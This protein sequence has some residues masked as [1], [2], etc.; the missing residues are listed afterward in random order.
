MGRPGT[1]GLATADTGVA[2]RQVWLDNLRVV[3]IGGVI[4]AHA[5]TAY[6]VEVSWYYEE[7]TT[8]E[9]ARM[10]VTF[11]VFL[12]AIFGLGPLFFVA[13][14]LSAQSLGRAGPAAFARTRL[15]RLGLPL[16][17]FVVVIDPLADYL[18]DL[19]GGH[20]SLGDYLL[21]RTSTRDLGP[22]WFV[23][24]LLTFSLGYAAWRTVRHPV[25]PRAESV[26]PAQLLGFSAAIA[27][28]SWV[29][30]QRW[31]YTDA[32]PFNTNVGHW[33]QAAG[34]FAL[35]VCCSERGWFDTLTPRRTHRQGWL[36]LAGTA[37]IAILAGYSLAAD[38]FPSMTGG[39]HWQS[40]VFAA[41]C[42]VT[43][44]AVSLWLAW[45]FRSRW[46]HAGRIAQRAGR[47]SYAAYLI[48]PLVLVLASLACWPLPVPPEVK[49]LVVACVGVPATFATGYALTRV[50]ALRRVL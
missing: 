9:L 34:L 31:T 18:G 37:L 10:V 38:D 28:A 4:V 27:L 13:G 42:G 50:P 14:L 36:A 17:V 24:A 6:I 7:R 35:G 5:A 19:A 29:V 47:G 25:N 39:L 26:A 32:T 44:V 21:D 43:G 20:D 23:A 2:P 8:S 3:L 46:N 12:A 41:V 49:F 11:P 22:M 16:L 1:P 48:H 33:G 45:W 30:W 40:V 15:L